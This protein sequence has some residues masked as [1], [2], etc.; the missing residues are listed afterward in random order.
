LL[1]IEDGRARCLG[2][3]HCEP[4]SAKQSSAEEAGEVSVEAVIASGLVDE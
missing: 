2:S 3:R 4:V 1:V